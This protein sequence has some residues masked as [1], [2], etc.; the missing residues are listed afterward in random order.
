M[1]APRCQV[2]TPMTDVVSH[3][4]NLVLNLVDRT[5]MILVFIPL[6]E[7]LNLVLQLPSCRSV[8]LNLVLTRIPTKFSSI[9]GYSCV[10]APCTRHARHARLRMRMMAC[11]CWHVASCM[12]QQYILMHILEYAR[13][14]RGSR[15]R[16][17]GACVRES[18]RSPGVWSRFF[19]ACGI[20]LR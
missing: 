19:A 15:G 17:H 10:H 8:V 9:P 11:I 7:V 1:P 4:R 6:R 2:M 14:T 13:A 3:D 12:Q 16:A 20:F 18:L 5:S